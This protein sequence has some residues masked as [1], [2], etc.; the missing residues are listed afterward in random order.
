MVGP[1]AGFVAA[2]PGAG[3]AGVAGA[4]GAAGAVAVPCTLPA[5]IVTVPTAP[6]WMSRY[7]KVPACVNW[8]G[9]VEPGAS[10]S[11]ANEPSDAVTVCVPAPSFVHT[12]TVPAGTSI[13]GGEKPVSVIA[14]VTVVAGAATRPVVA[15]AGDDA[16]AVT[17]VSDAS[18]V[19]TPNANTRASANTRARRTRPIWILPRWAPRGA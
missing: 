1:P 18:T 13:V 5:T 6:V 15:D 12:T 19:T 2:A 9:N 10:S 8:N 11:D 4:A 3:A 16:I 14:T 17:D 7:W